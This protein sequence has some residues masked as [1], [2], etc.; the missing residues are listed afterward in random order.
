M[1]KDNCIYRG[2]LDGFDRPTTKT[3]T[4]TAKSSNDD[5]DAD[6]DADDDDKVEYADG[7]SYH[8]TQGWYEFR[9][10]CLI[11]PSSASTTSAIEKTLSDYLATPPHHHDTQQQTYDYED[12]IRAYLLKTDGGD[13]SHLLLPND[14]DDS[15][16][17]TT[18]TTTAL[19]TLVKSIST[20]YVRMIAGTDA[21]LP[22]ILQEMADGKGI[23]TDGLATDHCVLLS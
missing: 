4:T 16:T 12:V 6:A 17:A 23:Y 7:L 22:V 21:L 14:G 3:S 18:T 2:W 11:Q 9:C 1:S 8:S 19:D 15:T 20:I 5:A 13:L 10:S